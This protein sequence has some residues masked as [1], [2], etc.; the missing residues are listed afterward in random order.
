M[1]ALPVHVVQS[2]FHQ[3]GG[4]ARHQRLAGPASGRQSFVIVALPIAAVW[5][6]TSADATPRFIL[7]LNWFDELR[8]QLGAQRR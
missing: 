2:R 3:L 4:W 5:D 7:T 6:G 1:I 8:R